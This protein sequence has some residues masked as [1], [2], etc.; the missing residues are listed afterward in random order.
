MTKV[1]LYSGGL[2]SFCMATAVQP[3]ILV[4]FDIGL[5]E[6]RKEIANIQNMKK[7]GVLPAP[8]VFDHRFNLA[9]YKLANEVMPFR[10][11][12]FVAAGFSY[13]DKLYLGKTASSRN[14]DKDPTFAAKALDV[15]KYIS[16]KPDKNPPGLLMEN[17]EIILPFDKKT[18]S[19]FLRE[20]L[21]NGGNLDHVLMTRSCYLP[22]GLEC[23]SCQ[24]CIRKSIALVNND[25]DI[26]GMFSTDPKLYYFTQYE[27]V[28]KVGNQLVIDEVKA[29]L[30]KV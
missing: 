24:S 12:F 25:V 2:D 21:E 27:D 9:P 18:K 23:G 3:D 7:A 1:V 22:E 30:A 5:L 15:L 14:L 17:M 10:N 11:L 20:F 8:I 28:L 13:G 6:Q 4:Y 29:A 19:T 26:R 16:Q